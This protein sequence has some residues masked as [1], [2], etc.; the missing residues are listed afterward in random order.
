LYYAKDI[1]SINSKID[2]LVNHGYQDFTTNVYNFASYGQTG[3]IIPG[4]QP[5]FLTDKP[6]NRLES[7]LARVNYT[8]PTNIY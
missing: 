2:V 6:Q 3:V 8:L 7:Y 4:T 5:V 1:K